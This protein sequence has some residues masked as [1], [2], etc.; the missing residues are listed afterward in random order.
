MILWEENM[1]SSIS[2]LHWKRWV[3]EIQQRYSY[4][5]G[6]KYWSDK[7]PLQKFLNFVLFLLTL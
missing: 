2:N 4:R 6:Y 5:N 3:K 1:N 7:N